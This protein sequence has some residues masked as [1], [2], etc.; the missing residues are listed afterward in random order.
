VPPDFVNDASIQF[1]AHARRVERTS[2]NLDSPAS[3]A[4][5]PSTP[6]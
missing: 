6:R 4:S 1:E 5:G 3:A 2:S